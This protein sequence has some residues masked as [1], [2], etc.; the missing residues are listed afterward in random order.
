MFKKLLGILAIFVFVFASF[1]IANAASTNTSAPMSVPH[2]SKSPI[3]VFIP[4]DEKSSAMNNAFSKWQSEA[5]NRITFAFVQDPKKADIIVKFTDSTDGLESKLGGYR[6]TT[7]GTEIKNAEITLATKSK[8]AKKY[9]NNY[10]YITMLHEV[11]HVL[12]MSDNS[13]K[14]TSI[15]Y[16]PISE[17]Q[18]IKK[19]DVRKLYKVNGWSYADRNMPSQRK[20]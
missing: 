10:I 16:M 12:G 11:G 8:L 4:K 7:N 20:N 5:G 1:N 3:N 19:I 2:W 18:S 17:E 13:T 9:S 6:V 14:P 15:M